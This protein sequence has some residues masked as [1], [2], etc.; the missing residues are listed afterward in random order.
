MSFVLLVISFLAAVALSDIRFMHYFQLN[1][2]QSVTQVHWMGKNTSKWIPNLVF[3]VM[4]IFALLS[5]AAEWLM[6]ACFLAAAY[7]TIPKKAKKPLVY[8][9]RV[10]RMFLCEA[11][12]LAIVL[13]L[14]H[15]IGGKALLVSSLPFWYLLSPMVVLLANFINKPI[16]KAVNQHFINEAKKILSEMPD[17]TI[18][19]VTGSFGKTSVKYYLNTLLRAQYNVLM[20]PESY[21][22][23]MGIVKTIRG[24][25]RATHEIFICEMGAKKVGEI[26]E[27]CDI[28]HPTHG[29]ITSIGPQHLETFFTLDNVKKTKFELADALPENGLLLLNGDDQNIADY[30]YPR[31]HLTYAI[32]HDADYRAF[33]L[34]V[35]E[36]GTSFSVKAPDGETERFTTKLIGTHN[37][38]NITGAIAFSHQLGIPLQK[39][40]AQVRKLECVPHRLQLLDH[41]DALVIDDAY[42]SN[43]TGTKAALDTLSLITG[44]KI[45]VTPGMVELGE[46]QEECNAEFGRNAAA[47][48]DYVIL[49]GKK[50]TEPIQKGLSEAGYPA[51]KIYLAD[52]IGEAVKKA[53]AIDTNGQKRVI[54]LENDLPDN[55]M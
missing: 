21:N 25:L 41:P 11:V 54:L 43:P 20:T 17:L 31:K 42:N 52:T 14:S 5:P 19:G 33:D 48:C 23:P 7:C 44:Y 6:A 15:G 8:T 53:Y 47:V 49:V 32:H 50:Q 40:K 3:S 36:K 22:T 55:Y 18:L 37:V 28:V 13:F 27:I 4:G 39:L 24:S 45:L 26:K 16:E 51:E 10:Q 46:K 38:L 12:L 34:E 35:S 29:I 1:S 2:Y 9:K 30:A